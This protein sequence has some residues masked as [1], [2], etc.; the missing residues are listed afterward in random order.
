MTAPWHAPGCVSAPMCTC[1][2]AEIARL[3]SAL[4]DAQRSADTWTEQARRYAFNADFWAARTDEAERCQA[5]QSQRAVAAEAER[6]EARAAVEAARGLALE[7]AAE[8]AWK[9]IANEYDPITHASHLSLA[10]TVGKRIR[11]L[12]RPTQK[13]ES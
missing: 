1:A 9:V 10:R 2:Q 4:E 3:T 11:A 5:V 6:D 13:E 8:H 7:E 12:A